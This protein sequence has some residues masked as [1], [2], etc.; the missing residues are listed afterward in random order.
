MYEQEIAELQNQ[1][2]LVKSKI[3]RLEAA[4][5]GGYTA[6]VAQSFHL[7]MVGGSGKNVGRLNRRREHEL[8]KTIDR[9]L[10]LVDLYKERNSLEVRIKDYQEDGPAKREAQKIEKN[11]RLAEW[12]KSLKIGDDARVSNHPVLITKK[13][14]KSCETGVGCKWTAREII[15]KEAAALL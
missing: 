4:Q 15:G 13:N 14:A 11:K 8:D 1:L 6:Q 2:E 7:G 5:N 12:W 10:V 9:A 3:S